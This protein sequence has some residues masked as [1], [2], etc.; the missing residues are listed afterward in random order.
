M[1]EKKTFRRYIIWQI[2]T[3]RHPLELTLETLLLVS[4]IPDRHKYSYF[5]IQSIRLLSV[6]IKGIK[7]VILLRCETGINIC[8]INKFCTSIKYTTA[9][10]NLLCMS[11][12]D[13]LV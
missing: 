1:F 3:G 10:S 2:R 4:L 12:L 11:F 13:S 9:L 8:S 5:G 6:E 7:G